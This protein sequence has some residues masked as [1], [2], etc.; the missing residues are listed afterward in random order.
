[1]LAIR[2]ITFS[3]LQP[4]CSLCAKFRWPKGLNLLQEALFN[5]ATI[6]KSKKMKRMKWY[7]KQKKSSEYFSKECAWHCLRDELS[8]FNC[9]NIIDKIHRNI[10]RCFI[11]N[12]L[13]KF[14]MSL[15]CK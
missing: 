7:L 9:R 6:C 1:M 8:T 5:Y 11:K 14:I 4:N 10:D 3:S 15:K 13:I 2:A 12:Y